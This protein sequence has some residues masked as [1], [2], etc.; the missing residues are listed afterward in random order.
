MKNRLRGTAAKGNVKAKTGS[1]GRVRALS[2]Y[3]TTRDGEELVFSMIANNYG[4]PMANATYIQDLVCERL[5][6]FTRSGD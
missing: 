3:V 2:G 6:N 1:I 5:A 4:V